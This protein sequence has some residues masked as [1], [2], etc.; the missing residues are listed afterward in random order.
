M[1]KILFFA[2]CALALFSCKKA[3]ENDDLKN[4]VL[5]GE[6]IEVTPFSATL[7]VS[8]SPLAYMHVKEAGIYVSDRP[9]AYASRWHYHWYDKEAKGE[10]NYKFTDLDPG[11]TYYYWAEIHYS[12]LTSYHETRGEVRSFTTHSIEGNLVTTEDPAEDSGKLR[13]RGSINGALLNVNDLTAWFEWGKIY[14]ESGE[15]TDAGRHKVDIKEDGTFE[16]WTELYEQAYCC[17]GITYK[18]KDYY[19]EEKTWKRK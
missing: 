12:T 9:D 5:T 4:L 14:P 7:S 2:F 11:T 16:Y 1:R 17:A 8:F 3:V 19:G 15:R 18:G 6:V 13:F 10:H